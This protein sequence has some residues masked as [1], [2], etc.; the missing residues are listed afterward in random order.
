MREK[1]FSLLEVIIALAIALI[2]LVA[3]INLEIRSAT[4]AAR[5]SIGFD[6]LPLAIERVEELTKREFSGTSREFMGEYEVQTTAVE[7]TSELPYTR[8]KVEVLYNGEPY[9]ELSIYKF[10]M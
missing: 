1:G 5:A 2:M 6:T 4:L 7:S 3:L 8:I 10:K 9:S